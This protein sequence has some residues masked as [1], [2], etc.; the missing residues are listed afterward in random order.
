MKNNPFLSAYELLDSAIM[1]GANSALRAYNWATGGTKTELSNDILTIAAV[2]DSAMIIQNPLTG[3]IYTSL[4]VYNSHFTQIVNNFQ[5]K[6]ENKALE[7]GAKDIW[8]ENRNKL[9]CLLGNMWGVSG[10]FHLMLSYS[11]FQAN[12]INAIPEAVLIAANLS[13]GLAHHVMRL[14]GMPPRKNC[15]SRGLEKLTYAY[16]S[17]T[18]KPTLAPAALQE[19]N[20]LTAF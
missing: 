2:L 4:Q 9:N 3:A 10:Y 19:Q 17:A 6:S 14:E 20:S 11:F 8:V 16:E 5:E 7:N 18:A 13:R 1:K 15:I 12:N